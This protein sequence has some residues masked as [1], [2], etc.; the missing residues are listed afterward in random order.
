MFETIGLDPS[1]L[2]KFV[3]LCIV[4]V[5]LLSYFSRK[6]R[7]SSAPLPPGPKPLPIIGNAHQLPD[8]YQEKEFFSWGQE[9]GKLVYAK[10]LNKQMVVINSLDVARDLMEKRGAIYSD[11]PRFVLLNEMLDLDCNVPLLSYSNQFRKT[12]KWIQD[13]FSSAALAAYRPRQ[14]R[15]T[16]VML[17]GILA[18]PTAFSAHIARFTEALIM[19]I[20]YGHIVTSEDDKY[21]EMGEKGNHAF[22][23]VGSAGS[24]LVDFFPIRKAPFLVTDATS[25]SPLAVKHYPTW[26]PGA[27]FKKR[28]ISAAKLLRTMHDVPYNMVKSQLK[29]GNVRASFTATLLDKY[30][31]GGEFNMSSQDEKDI[32]GSA[33][34]LY[35]AGTETMAST[36]TTFLL[37]MLLHPHIYGKLQEEMDNVIGP[38][39]LPDFDDRESLPYLHAVIK[40]TYR[41]HAP[42]P[43]GL[44]HL[45]SQEDIYSGYKIPNKTTIVGN[46]WG[47]SRD[48]NLYS[49]AD[50]FLPERFLTAKE[51]VVD[52][53]SYVFGFGRRLCPG[54]DF[55]DTC[56]FLV[57][58]SIV[59]TMTLNKAKDE[60]G[61]E[62]TPLPAFTSGFASRPKPFKCIM[63]PRS[64]QAIRLIRQLDTEEIVEGMA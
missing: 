48:M 23:T 29:F 27:A 44:P 46:I 42:L 55:A 24:M 57:L 16:N 49:D 32:K 9:F 36:M 34:T 35:A 20:A 2:G 58:A 33:G 43:M 45:S 37:A 47:I 22:A 52:P 56:V 53:R 5:S 59:A 63:L 14:R 7:S 64:Q 54:K 11:R 62:I 21:I 19:D 6:R 60:F 30:L 18:R 10:A 39:R 41:W 61:V 17:K 1:T 13:S 15:E 50:S 51:D 25:D 4:A 31:Y 3:L 28:A 12:R 26:L 38:S 40:E 8:E